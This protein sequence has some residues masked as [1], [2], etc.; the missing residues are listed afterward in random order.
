[1]TFRV[2]RLPLAA[3]ALS[4][5][6]AFGVIAPAQARAA[7]DDGRAAL[8]P[9]NSAQAVRFTNSGS[10]GGTSTIQNCFS[11]K[12]RVAMRIHN[13]VGLIGWDQN[14]RCVTLNP[15]G[16]TSMRNS[17]SSYG[18]SWAAC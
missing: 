18:F 12:K 16:K 8:G 1:M 5:S 9:C 2:H 11:T 15:G 3:L 10:N 7:V 14:G 13:V 4:A 17:V 6:L